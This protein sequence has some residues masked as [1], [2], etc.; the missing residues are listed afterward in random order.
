MCVYKRVTSKRRERHDHQK[1]TLIQQTISLLLDTNRPDL[2]DTQ[3][4]QKILKFFPQHNLKNNFI[5]AHI[6]TFGVC[7]TTQTRPTANPK[8]ANFANAF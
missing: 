3:A 8:R 4:G 1:T 6:G 2:D 5:P 7:S